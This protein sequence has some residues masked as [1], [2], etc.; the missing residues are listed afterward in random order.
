MKTNIKKTFGPLRVEIEKADKKRDELILK[1]RDIIKLSKKI[2]Y[3][4]QRNDLKTAKP[5][6]SNIKTKVAAL[7][8]YSE[9]D[10]GSYRVAMQE[11]VEAIAF[12]EFVNSKKL[13]T[14]AALNV[15]AEH[16][17]LGICDLTG[18][19]VRRA[20]NMAIKGNK[21]EALAI[22]DF[23]SDVYGE[24]MQFDFRNSELR[25]KFDG[26]KYD[27]KKLE[28]LALNLKLKR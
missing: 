21:K 25:R 22:K 20:I 11:Y 27:L 12:Y 6:I 17:L 24:L 16:Y 18:E 1:S 10:S 5:L 9:C 8:K 2:I 28:D 3:S 26:I 19:L 13:P 14:K 4:V 23:V 15:S 7:K